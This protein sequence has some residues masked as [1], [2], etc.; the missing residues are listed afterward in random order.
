[1]C[2]EISVKKS[3]KQ[4]RLE[5]QG[6]IFTGQE[7]LDNHELDMTKPCYCGRKRYTRSDANPIKAND[8]K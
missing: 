3:E 4:I 1:M 8:E 7:F 6:C 5:Q 2:N